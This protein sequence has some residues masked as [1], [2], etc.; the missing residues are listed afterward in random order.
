MI[1]AASP[2][3]KNVLRV[4]QDA[5]AVDLGVVRIDKHEKYVGLP[6]ELSYSKSY[7]FGFLLEK[8]KKKT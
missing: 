1:R 7:A 3:V 4:I 5:M 2:L 6:T 8:A